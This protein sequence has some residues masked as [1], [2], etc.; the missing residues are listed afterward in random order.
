MV[1]RGERPLGRRKESHRAILSD[2]GVIVAGRSSTPVS[3]RCRRSGTVVTRPPSCRLGAHQRVLAQK[4]YLVELELPRHSVGD[5]AHSNS[6]ETRDPD[7]LIDVGREQT[8][9]RG[10]LAAHASPFRTL[11]NIRLKAP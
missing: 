5:G 8:E 9:Q 11:G 10:I 3:C 2:L 6:V 7:L 4:P 1:K